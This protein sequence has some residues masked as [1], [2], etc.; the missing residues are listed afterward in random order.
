[1]P[2]QFTIHRERM[3]GCNHQAINSTDDHDT[4]GDAEPT[5]LLMCPRCYEVSSFGPHL[6]CPI[7]QHHLGS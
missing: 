5:T 6:T 1:M 4:N 7:C 2:F 3:A